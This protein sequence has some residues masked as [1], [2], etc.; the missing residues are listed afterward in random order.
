MLFILT[1][2]SRGAPE[3]MTVCSRL[4]GQALAA[5]RMLG[6]SIALWP[7]CLAC[8]H[9]LCS[10]LATGKPGTAL[11]P[12]PSGGCCCMR[13]NQRTKAA[14]LC[15]TVMVRYVQPWTPLVPYPARQGERC[16]V[17]SRGNFPM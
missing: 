16:S 9:A 12:W 14:L 7:A 11:G 2:S 8:V 5:L 15:V 6:G 13:D 10:R 17:G 4:Q 3:R 1:A